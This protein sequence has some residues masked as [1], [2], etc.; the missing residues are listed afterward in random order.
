MLV[1]PFRFAPPDASIAYAGFASQT[2][3]TATVSVS[4]VAI[5]AAGANRRV[6]I[7][8]GIKP[9]AVYQS[10]VS[11]TIGGV[12]ATLHGQTNDTTYKY[13][14]ALIS[15]AVSTGTTA[16]ISLTFSGAGDVD[17]DIYLASY[18]AYGLLSSTPVDLLTSNGDSLAQ[19]V[20]Q[21]VDVET[22]KGGVVLMGACVSAQAEDFDLSGVV[23][24][25]QTTIDG[26]GQSNS[27]VVFIG[28][29]AL[30]DEDNASF[31]IG[32]S[33]SDGTTKHFDRTLA[34]SF[35]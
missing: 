13:N 2:F 33:S 21:T 3:T 28:G 26:P 25:F 29:C 17:G 15:A 7:L 12:S 5:G 11:A 10:L 1:D 6:F 27:Y 35:R 8:V 31:D 24:N 4:S 14:V 19:E 30:T 32:I 22:K 23:E 9:G 20:T 34:A 16:T 18:A